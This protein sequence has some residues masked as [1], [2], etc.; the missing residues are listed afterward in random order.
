MALNHLPLWFARSIETDAE[1][2]V[3]ISYFIHLYLHSLFVRYDWFARSVWV[4]S[5]GFGSLGFSHF[6]V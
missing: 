5:V 3:K 6:S 4:N 2:S 1:P